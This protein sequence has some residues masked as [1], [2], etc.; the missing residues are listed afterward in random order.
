V[1]AE[2]N[3]RARA[4]SERGV[5]FAPVVAALALSEARLGRV[6]AASRLMDFDRFLHCGRVDPP[7]GMSMA[8]F[9]QA[10]A[11]AIKSDLQY[12]EAPTDRAI[13]RAWRCDNVQNLPDPAV[14]D[15]WRIL[16][17]HVS[18][19]I[20]GLPADQSHPF[21][22]ACPREFEI[23]GWAVVS[24]GSSHHNSHLHP[25]AWATGVYYV[26]QPEISRRSERGWL[27]IGPPP[28]LRGAWEP[29]LIEPV[30]GSF[31]LMPGYFWHETEPMGVDQERICI[32]FEVRSPELA[33]GAGDADY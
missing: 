21:L 15:F 25:R 14:G 9:N 11:D 30:P 4:L 29:R 3:A 17:G 13:C 26:V 12:Y 22:A 16:R 31:V 33:L 10:L 23:G 20:E 27:R 28:K 24:D 18:R 2:L 32:A 6:A 5:L 8:S 1:A 7:A 19:Y